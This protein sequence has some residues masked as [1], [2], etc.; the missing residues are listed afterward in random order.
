MELIE[1]E[2]VIVKEK[3]EAKQLKKLEQLEKL[4]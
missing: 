3:A 1:V 2:A 4:E